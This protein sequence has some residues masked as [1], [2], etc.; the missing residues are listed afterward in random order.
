MPPN[1]ATKQLPVFIAH[2]NGRSR[3]YFPKFFVLK[4]LHLNP[5][6]TRALVSQQDTVA[7]R[8]VQR[9]VKISK[10]YLNLFRNKILTRSAERRSWRCGA[11]DSV[12]RP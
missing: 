4:I 5:H 12:D 2:T 7:L 8:M 10:P 6:F 9:K 3:G 11:Y 1:V